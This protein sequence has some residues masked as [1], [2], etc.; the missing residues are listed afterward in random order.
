[1]LSSNSRLA[2]LIR[3]PSA[4]VGLARCGPALGYTVEA[5]LHRTLDTIN[6]RSFRQRTT[7]VLGG[8]ERLVAGDYREL[9]V[10]IPGLLGFRRLLHLEQIEVMHHAAVFEY[11]AALREHVVDR[12]LL[13][14][15]G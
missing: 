7:A 1:M 8:W 2:L 6:L 13:Q 5:T 15:L 12:Q 10:V 4:S 11:L 3:S 9:L 14:L